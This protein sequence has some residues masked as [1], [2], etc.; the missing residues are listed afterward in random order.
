MTRFRIEVMDSEGKVIRK[1]HVELSVKTVREACV[2][3]EVMKMKRD[4][5]EAKLA[6]RV[7]IEDEENQRYKMKKQLIITYEGYSTADDNKNVHDVFEVKFMNGDVQ[8][9]AGSGSFEFVLQLVNA[10][11]LM[12]LKD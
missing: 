3:D 7:K 2:N 5:K 6:F 11:A 12:D 4:A 1:K 10:K 8:I 9:W